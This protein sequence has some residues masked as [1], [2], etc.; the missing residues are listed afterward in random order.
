MADIRENGWEWYHYDNPDFQVQLRKNYIP[1]GIKI[2]DIKS[3]HWHDYLE[4]IYVL[5]GATHY[6]MADK[7]VKMTAGEGIFVNSKQL[8]LIHP[9]KDEDC[10]LICLIFHPIILCSTEHITNT[11]VKPLI[12]NKNIQYVHLKES[13]EWQ[14]RVLHDIAD[15]EAYLEDENGHLKTMSLIFDIWEQLFKNLVTN[16]SDEDV[17]FDLTCMKRMIQ[18][19]HKN[20]M[21]KISLQKIC[22]AGNVGRSKCNALFEKYYNVSPIE[23][24]KNFRIEQGAKL[25]TM[26]DMS[27]TEIAYETGFTDGSYFSKAFSNKI[28][29]SPLKYRAIGKGMSRYYELPESQNI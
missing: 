24:V 22:E 18:Y 2:Q 3:I 14:K 4:F 10:L 8:H 21:N 15:M 25:L 7:M 19:I 12:E 1:A 27:V 9:D 6:E 28:G 29:I 5:Q 17:S 23:Y 26:S 16:E 13:N 20:Y 11:Y